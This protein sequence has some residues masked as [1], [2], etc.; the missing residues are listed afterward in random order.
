MSFFNVSLPMSSYITREWSTA[1][2]EEE[3]GIKRGRI[4]TTH[5]CSNSLPNA[6]LSKKAL[7]GIQW[8]DREVKGF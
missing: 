4:L 8:L 6:V 7:L 3:G 5:S 2:S 1:H